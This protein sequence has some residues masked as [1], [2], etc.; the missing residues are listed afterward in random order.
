MEALKFGGLSG[1]RMAEQ[2]PVLAADKVAME[3]TEA[4]EEMAF[5]EEK[6]EMVELEDKGELVAKA[7]LEV[8]MIH[9]VKAVMAVMAVMAAMEVAEVKVAMEVL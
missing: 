2:L 6:V 1:K 7:K 5:K 8:T 9:V 3:E 4:E